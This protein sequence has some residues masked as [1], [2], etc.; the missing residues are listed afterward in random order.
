MA[1]SPSKRRKLSPDASLPLR[2]PSPSRVPAPYDAAQT[3]PGRPSFAAPTRASIAR[4]NPQLLARPSS[5]GHGDG[6][7]RS[8]G[9]TSRAPETEPVPETQSNAEDLDANMAM[10]MNAKDLPVEGDK[11]RLAGTEA[12]PTLQPSE[13]ELTRPTEEISSTAAHRGPGRV[14][15]QDPETFDRPVG[16]ASTKEAAQPATAGKTVPNPLRSSDLPSLPV[17]SQ[18]AELANSRGS[19]NEVQPDLPPTPVQRGLEDPIVTM[20]PSG[21][22][23]TPSKRPKRSRGTKIKPSPLKPPPEPEAG[24]EVG[25]SPKRRRTEYPARHL[26]PI[27]PHAETRRIRDKLL[28]EVE[29]LQ[30]DVAIA[31][32]ENERL[33]LGYQSNK[34][35]TEPPNPDELVSLLQRWTTESSPKQSF[36]KPTS[37]FHAISSF[38]PFSPRS[39][40]KIETPPKE[41]PVS[42]LPAFQNDQLLYLQLF[43]PLT[44]T[45]TVT[46]LPSTPPEPD[47]IPTSG[48]L[49]QNHTITAKAP[50]GIFSARLSITVSTTS[51]SISHLE[52]QGLDTCA[53]AEFGRWA[54]ERARG[55]GF[56]GRDVNA[57]CI[58]MA[59]WYEVALR[60]ARFWCTIESE[61]VTEDGRK[62]S[63]EGLKARRKWRRRPVNEEAEEHGGEEGADEVLEAENEKEKVWTRKQLLPQMKRSSLVLANDSVELRIE[64]T[65]VIDWTGEAESCI[66][67]SARVPAS[68]TFISISTL[69][70]ET[71][72]Y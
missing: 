24:L 28:K 61:L 20:P 67:A 59:R 19:E 42:H 72:E 3:T 18:T 52:I 45:S 13:V 71:I 17:A 1:S 51:F 30:K 15:L 37:I 66:S 53:E 33:R 6:R 44:Y 36:Q 40:P 54:R 10:S 2:V 7:P 70:I 12:P 57:I 34:K 38:L 68:C 65:I 49:F 64:W 56:L 31:E 48:E 4:Y 11:G 27:D 39:R 35:S 16:A 46:L 32:Q 29:Q 55:K 26:V 63:T 5:A 41:I 43:T 22:H 14:A 25:R 62:R 50:S 9:D 47:A 8:R 21:I 58:G 69:Q 60:R 23:N